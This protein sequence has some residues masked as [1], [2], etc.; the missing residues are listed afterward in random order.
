MTPFWD[1][2]FTP[3]R[4][5]NWRPHISMPTGSPDPDSSCTLRYESQ[6]LPPIL[7]VIGLALAG[8]ATRGNQANFGD[9]GIMTPLDEPVVP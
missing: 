9:F 5:V 2:N 4:V 1:P 6:V 3:P 8:R 7:V